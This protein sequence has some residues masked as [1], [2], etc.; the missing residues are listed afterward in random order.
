MYMSREHANAQ[1]QSIV[2]KSLLV[3]MLPGKAPHSVCAVRCISP[4]L[5][6]LLPVQ[7]RRRYNPYM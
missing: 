1:E 6:T 3:T 2:I 4:L 7:G 5:V